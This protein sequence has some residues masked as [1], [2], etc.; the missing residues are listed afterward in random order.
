MAFNKVEILVDSKAKDIS[1]V[2][3]DDTDG[4]SVETTLSVEDA[5]EVVTQLN[6]A[7]HKLTQV[8][9]KVVHNRYPSKSRTTH[10]K[11]QGGGGITID[12]RGS[13]PEQVRE[14]VLH[15]VDSVRYQNSAR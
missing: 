10:K 4:S 14:A 12:A 8:E 6:V 7:I 5:W 9:P 15:S 1:L 2:A 3:V 11:E 13:N